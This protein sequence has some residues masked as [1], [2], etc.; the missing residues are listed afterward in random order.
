MRLKSFSLE[1]FRNYKNLDFQFPETG[2]VVFL[3]ENAQGKTNLLEAIFILALTKSFNPILQK[4]TIKWEQEYSRVKG[5]IKSEQ[6][7]EKEL[8]VF[9]GK[10]RK[11]PKTLKINSAKKKIAE[12]VGNFLVTLFTPQDL[13]LVFL[14]PQYRRR[15]IDILNAQIDRNYLEQLILYQ[16][17][18]RNRNRLL[19][20]IKGKEAKEDEL[21]YWDQKLVEYGSFVYFARRGSLKTINEL[22]S[23]YYRE[24]SGEDLE[25]KKR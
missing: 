21:V 6:E 23:K 15:Y 20:Y 2:V 12:Y 7:G 16:E 3:G 13:N 5:V 24:I 25:L 11:Y 14:S 22:I 10:Q 19:A 1:N 18:L 8:E 9:W 4:D 17:V